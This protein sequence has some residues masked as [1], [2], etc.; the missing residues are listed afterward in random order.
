[1]QGTNFTASSHKRILINTFMK[2][3]LRMMQWCEKVI[4]ELPVAVTENKPRK[5]Q[6]E[7]PALRLEPDRKMPGREWNMRA[8]TGI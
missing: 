3:L 6:S 2:V 7:I 8:G 5:W 1:M 4:H